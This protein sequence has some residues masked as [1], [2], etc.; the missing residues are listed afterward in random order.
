MKIENHLILQIL[1]FFHLIIGQFYVPAQQWIKVLIPN[2]QTGPNAV[3]ETYDKG[4]VTGGFFW[5]Q[6][7]TAKD[8]F[9]AKTDINGNMLWYKTIGENDGGGIS[10]VTNDLDGGLI[11]TGNTSKLTPWGDPIIIKLDPCMEVSW[12]RIY[13]TPYPP[14]G[15]AGIS[16]YPL[17]DGGYITLM[18]YFGTLHEERISLFRLDHDGDLIW[19]K[20]Y[21]AS[22]PLVM[23]QDCYSLHIG[24]DSSFIISAACDYPIPGTSIYWQRPYLIKTNSNGDMDWDL[25]W[26][27]DS[28][29]VIG[30]QIYRSV[31]DNSG[32]I[33]SAGARYRNISPTGSSPTLYVTSPEGTELYYKDIIPFSIGGALNTINWLNDSTLLFGGGYSY[34][35]MDV[36]NVAFKT[37]VFG[38]TIK[39]KIID[40]CNINAPVNIYDAVLTQD[41]KIVFAASKYANNMA[42]TYLYKLNFAL[43]W[44][45]IYTAPLVYDSLCPHPIPSDTIAQDCVIVGLD[46]PRNLAEENKLLVYPNPATDKITIVIPDKL[47]KES[48]TT[49]FNVTT[50]FYQWDKISLEINTFEGISVFRKEIPN[51]MKQI[52]IDVSGWKRGMYLLRILKGNNMVTSEKILIQ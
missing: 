3:V 36:K 5:G 51:P 19:Q 47:V 14:W 52:E 22:D 25:I 13:Y 35:Q 26:G 32:T 30:T 12:C 10:D 49:L 4:Y 24:N 45:S 40:V 33:Y 20:T 34:S 50:V 15:D 23:N 31:T 41:S 39:T 28:S 18:R 21:L 1:L 29:Y 6:G 38:D 48:R 43:D 27:A 2:K 9:I 16:I 44:D 46:E 37:N 42:R 7:G 17:T 11:L 8:G